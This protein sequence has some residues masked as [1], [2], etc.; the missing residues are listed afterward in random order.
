MR[1]H[2][3]K[4]RRSLKRIAGVVLMMSCVA[5]I[6]AS[7]SIPV[8][9]LAQNSSVAQAGSAQSASGIDRHTDRDT[10][11]AAPPGG[12]KDAEDAE[13]AAL[14]GWHL[15][16]NNVYGTSDPEDLPHLR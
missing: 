3:S 10:P 9:V 7:I 12:D 5:G 16:A 4:T 11:A 13:V 15:N 14:L 8:P 1:I 6:A 2:D